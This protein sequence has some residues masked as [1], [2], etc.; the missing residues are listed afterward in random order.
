MVFGFKNREHN[1]HGILTEEDIRNRLYGSAVGIAVDTKDGHSKKRDR[2]HKPVAQKGPPDDERAK[3]KDELQSLKRELEQTKRKLDRMRGLKAKKMRLL[4]TSL[5]I[6]FVMA[7]LATFTLRR[8]FRNDNRPAAA[9]RTDAKYSIQ[10]AVSDSE[11]GA[12]KLNNDLILKGYKSF[13]YKSQFKS[14]KDK[15]IIYVGAFG[16]KRSASVILNRL[17][18][19]E[20]IGDSYITNMPK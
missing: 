16:E 15:F 6:F 1:G 9:V 3:I 12:Q 18:T 8:I 14:G 4:I 13:I 20:G 5:I 19:K 17:K 11:A 10:V 2:D 7:M